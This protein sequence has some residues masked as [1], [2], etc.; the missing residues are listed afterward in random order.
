MSWFDKIK[1]SIKNTLSSSENSVIPEGVWTKCDSCG[2]TLYSKDYEANLHVCHHC[3]HHSRL[4]PRT[5]LS[6]LLD[7]DSMVELFANV[8][9][10]DPLNFKD[11]KS[12]KDRLKTAKKHTGE[13]D[14]LTV[15]QG[16]T[17]GIPVVACAF[18][19][20]FMGGSMGSVV[21]E[22]FTRAAKLAMESDAALICFSASGGARMQEGLIS[23]MQ[24]AK[25]SAIL[26]KLRDKGIPFISVLTDPTLGGVS[27]SLAMLGDVI[28]AEPKALIGFAGPRVIEQTIREKLPEGFQRAEF[29]LEHGAIDAIVERKD[30]KKYL[31]SLVS[32]LKGLPEPVIP[33]EVVATEVENLVVATL[34]TDPTPEA[35]V[36]TVMEEPEVIVEVTDSSEASTESITTEITPDIQAEAPV[37]EAEVVS[38]ASD[39]SKK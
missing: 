35:E 14:A 24:M 6:N 36:V 39:T 20:A 15:Y 10:L 32:K 37:V 12:Y 27:A 16:T 9:P 1:T 4:D 3:G 29:L 17:Y 5:R 21:G 22:R 26:A 31:A 13:D 30:L 28:I 25:T 8:Q 2:Q 34:E 23:L 7:K 18:N 33:K 19:M 38:E 11:L